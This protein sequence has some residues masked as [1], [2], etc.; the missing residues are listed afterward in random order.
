MIFRKKVNSPENQKKVEI[1]IFAQSLKVYMMEVLL[2]K[3]SICLHKTLKKKK[4]YGVHN[5][6]HYSAQIPKVKYSRW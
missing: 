6:H 3:I 1:S 5:Y 2:T 4:K